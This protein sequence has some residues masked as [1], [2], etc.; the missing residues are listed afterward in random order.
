MI[1]ALIVGVAVYFVVDRLGRPPRVLEFFSPV[2]DASAIA[3]GILAAVKTLLPTEG[4]IYEFGVKA[5]FFKRLDAAFYSALRAC[6]LTVAITIALL[7]ANSLIVQESASG[8]SPETAALLLP[9][10]TYVI[11]VWSGIVA[12]AALSTFR[13]LSIAFM[14]LSGR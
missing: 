4:R 7:F 13:A 9:L 5:N 1:W 6:G 3:I 2:I 8:F 12:W 14:L 11:A 10:Q